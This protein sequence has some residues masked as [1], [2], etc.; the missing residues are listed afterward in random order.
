MSIPLVMEM[1][2]MPDWLNIYED[3]LNQGIA[4]KRLRNILEISISDAGDI[5]L[6]KKV[7]TTLD[8]VNNLG[9]DEI[10]KKLEKK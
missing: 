9:L 4:W 2:M 8:K 10:N 7:L 6:T 3:A 1:G 5:D